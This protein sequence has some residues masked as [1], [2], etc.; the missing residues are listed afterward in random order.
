[1]FQNDTSRT[2]GPLGQFSDAKKIFQKFHPR[3]EKPLLKEA[4]LSDRKIIGQTSG[5]FPYM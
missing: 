5:P 3:S 4:C 2:G 1:M